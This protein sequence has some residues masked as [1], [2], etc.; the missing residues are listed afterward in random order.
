MLYASKKWIVAQKFEKKQPYSHIFFK[1][2]RGDMTE[3][4]DQIAFGSG[5]QDSKSIILQYVCCN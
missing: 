2:F 4:I 5:P 1:I 3:K